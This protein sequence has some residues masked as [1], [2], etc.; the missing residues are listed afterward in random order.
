MRKSRDKIAI[1]LREA[2]L[3]AKCSR[4]HVEHHATE[5]TGKHEFTTWC[6]K[7]GRSWI[8]RDR[9]GWHHMIEVVPPLK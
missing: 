1:G 4:K 9:G 5:K 7:C 6:N 8:T 3:I 2:G